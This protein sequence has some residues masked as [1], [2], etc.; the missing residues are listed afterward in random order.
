MCGRG[1]GYRKRA[2]GDTQGGM[3]R[4]LQTDASW[5]LLLQRLVLGAVLLPHGLQKVFGW[6]GGYG[7]DGTMGYFTSALG[8]PAP[9]AALV[10]LAESL[11]ALAL[12]LGAGTRLAAVGAIATMLGAVFMVHAPN[13]FFMNWGGTAAG[14]GFEYHLLAIGL[15]LPLAIRGGG[16]AS[17][18]RALARRLDAA[19]PTSRVRG[20]VAA[21]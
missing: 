1:A 18:D 9:L 17:I 4:F 2:A 12:I 10:I 3:K 7:W 14:E 13:G 5:P 20:A 6:F 15:A 11:G 19:T 8:V 16:L 21:A